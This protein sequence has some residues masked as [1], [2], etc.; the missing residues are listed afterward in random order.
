[1]PL[2]IAGARYCPPPSASMVKFRLLSIQF[3]G[4]FGED[5]SMFEVVVRYLS[6]C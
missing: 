4:D 2:P 1:M 3:V 5:Q 6:L